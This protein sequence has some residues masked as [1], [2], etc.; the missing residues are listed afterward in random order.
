MLED[1]GV[2][3]VFRALASRV[4][5]EILFHLRDGELAAGEIASRFEIAAPT[6]SRHLGVLKNAGLVGERREG[7][8]IL[9]QAAQDRIAGTLLGFVGTVGKSGGYK[10][11]RRKDS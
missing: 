8:R 4:R 10:G 1:A 9:Y 3:G 7:N 11:T 5:R 2:E 6:V